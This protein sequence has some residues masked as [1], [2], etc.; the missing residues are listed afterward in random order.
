M[1]IRRYRPT[2]FDGVQSLWEEAF[3]NDPPWNR[4]EIAVPAKLAFQPDL[5][6]VAI[7]GGGVIG[8][9]MAGYDGHRGWLYAVAVQE[10]CQRG[11]V[12]AALVRKAESALAALG[13]E[14]VNLQVRASNEA[15]ARFYTKLGYAVEDRISLGRRLSAEP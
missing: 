5:L 11:G 9:V 3:P 7:D 4:A 10:D 13:C 14:K 12:G 8:S 2:D 6:F 1:E 15:V